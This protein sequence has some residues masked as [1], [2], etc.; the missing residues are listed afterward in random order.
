MVVGEEA[1]KVVNEIPDMMVDEVPDMVVAKVAD[2]EVDKM[3]RIVFFWISL[4]FFLDFSVKHFGFLDEL[5]NRC[6]RAYRS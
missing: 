3:A 2:I 5:W 6:K 4:L 1:D